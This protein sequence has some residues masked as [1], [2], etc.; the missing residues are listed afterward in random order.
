MFCDH[1]ALIF[2]LLINNPYHNFF[3]FFSKKRDS[4]VFRENPKCP[5]PFLNWP[6]KIGK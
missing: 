1:Y 6:G 4:K 5:C 3:I 2:S